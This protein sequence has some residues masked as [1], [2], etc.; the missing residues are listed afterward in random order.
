MTAELW[1]RRPRDAP[2]ILVPRKIARVRTSPQLLFPKFV[3]G[4]CSDRYQERAYKIG[5]SW[6]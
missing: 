6:L 5:R 3:M 2:N 1:Q 4:V